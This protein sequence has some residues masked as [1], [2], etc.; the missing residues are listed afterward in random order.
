MVLVTTASVVLL[1][2]LTTGLF[3]GRENENEAAAVGLAQEK[4]EEMRNETFAGVASESRAAVSG[5]SP[6]E[7]EVVVSTV[8]TGLKQVTVNVY[9][10]SK[11]AELSSNLVTYV[12]DI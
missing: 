2:A 5:F 10:Q 9:W 1:Q 7:R 4:M 6:Y 8:Q 12:S 11:S 3:A